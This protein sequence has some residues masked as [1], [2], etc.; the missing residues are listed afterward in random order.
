VRVFDIAV[1]TAPG[2]VLGVLGLGEQ[3]V[4]AGEQLAGDRGGGDLLAAGRAIA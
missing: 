2:G 1:V 4:G 3:V